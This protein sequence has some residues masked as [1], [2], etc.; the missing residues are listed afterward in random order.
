MK[1]EFIVLG[2]IVA[3]ALYLF[4]TQKLH[5]DVTAVLVMLSLA[6]PW[7]RPDG[8]WSAILSPQEAFSGF[9][10]V[11]V[12]MVTAMFVFS[13]SMIR[14]GAA[15]MIG[16]RLFR[17]CAH[18][19]ILLQVAILSISAACAMFIHETT[20]VLVLMPIVLAVCKE[21]HLSPSRY[22][23]CAAYGAALGGQWTLIGTRSN[24]IVSDFLRQRTGQGI[25]FFDFTPVAA[26]V[27]AGCAIYFFL[28]GRRFLPGAEAQSLEQELGKEYLTEV[29]VTPQSAIIGS[30]LDQLEW[31]KRQ[32]ITI[33]GVI[34][35]GERMPPNGWMKV[36]PGDALIMQGAVPTM[37]GLLKSPDFQLMEELKIG[38]RT[39]RSLDL[40]TVEALLSPNSRYTGRT[41]QNTNF[42]RDYGFSVLGIS[43]HGQTIQERPS[44]TR[45]EYGDSLLLLG[46][47]SN[48]ERLGRNPNLI[49]LSQSPFPTMAKDKAVITM[50]LLLGIIVMAVTNILTPAISIPLAAMAALLLGCVKLSDTYKSVNWPAIA[51]VGGMISLGLA[52]EKTGAAE[53]LAH[54]IVTGFQWAG[55]ISIFCAL[56][57]FTVALTQLIENAAVAIILAP[58]AYQI[59]HESHV[60]PKPFMVGL[61]ICISTSFCTPVAHETTMLVMGPGRY[62]FKNYLSIGS[63]MAVIA[64]LLVTF[65][66][67]KI[68]KF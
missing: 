22:L 25:G 41:L 42:G 62:R 66:T 3:G 28:V 67:P 4:W 11:A 54:A 37:S 64:W 6:V 51:T 10:S 63:G 29:M 1:P 32:D 56:L 58:I 2:L 9:G 60:D 49:L 68:W 44:A 21:R 12:I 57:A 18:H 65:V 36:H 27:F 50:L 38:E 53:A 55:P 40:I 45:L 34:R 26:V 43:R 13:A 17:A 15:E 31:A 5:T 20:T 30:R 19:E 8:R 47:N 16:G 46:H 24:I 7:P 23:L 35:E 52:L 39:L 33:V 48:L 14:T 59:A 61:A